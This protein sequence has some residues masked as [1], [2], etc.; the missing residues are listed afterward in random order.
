M[1]ATATATTTTPS[2]L[3][4]IA[5]LTATQLNALLDLAGAA[6]IPV[7]NA[8]TDDHNPCQALADPLTLRRHY[9]YLDGIRL[10]YAGAGNNVAHSLMEAGALIMHCLP[11]PAGSR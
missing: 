1:T 2:N 8:L 11:R 4:R 6:S 10:A 9:G 5:D 7:V 3:L